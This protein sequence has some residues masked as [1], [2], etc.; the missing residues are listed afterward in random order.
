MRTG[1]TLVEVVIVVLIL[2][3]LGAVTVPAFRAVTQRDEVTAVADDLATLLR[4][5]R[6]AALER[7]ATVEL[8]IDPSTGRYWSWIGQGTG[9]REPFV[10]G[11]LDL[12][13][14]T[15]LEAIGPRVGFTFRS[16]GPPGGGLVEVVGAGSGAVV[17]VDPWTGDPRVRV[18]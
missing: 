12:P 8:T 11:V 6:L 17:D 3:V 7:G 14:G 13:D 10:A 16:A 1:F 4:S 2:G 15:R 18:R 5:A 9:A